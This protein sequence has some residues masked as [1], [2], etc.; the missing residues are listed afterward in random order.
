MTLKEPPPLLPYQTMIE[1]HP[2][3]WDLIIGVPGIGMKV[4]QIKDAKGQLIGHVFGKDWREAELIANTIC[5]SVSAL[6]DPSVFGKMPDA[7]RIISPQP[8]DSH[9]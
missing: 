8:C 7:M 4:V 5:F 1:N 6:V 3:P 2:L 9:S